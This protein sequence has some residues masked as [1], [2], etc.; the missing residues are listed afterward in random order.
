M[1]STT[2]L[3]FL[4]AVVL[5]FGAGACNCGGVG[6][7]DNDAGM[8]GGRGDGGDDGSGDGGP[9]AQCLATGF[10]CQTASGR[11]CCSGTCSNGSCTEPTFCKGPGTA[12]TAGTECCSN[13]CLEGKCSATQCLDVGQGCSQNGSCCTFNCSGGTCANIPGQ[14]TGPGADGGSQPVCRVL[15]QA[16]SAGGDCCSRNCQGGVCVRSF[17]CNAYNDICL[18]NADCCSNVC[19]STDGGAGY[20]VT[21]TGQTGCDQSGIPCENGTNC[22]TRV[23]LDQGSGVK[24]CQPV[25][26][27]RVAGDYCSGDTSCCGG[28]PTGT[29]Q[30]VATSS[31][32]DNGQACRAPGTIC[33]KPTM[34]LA[35]GGYDWVRLPDGGTF[36]VNNETNCCDGY[37]IPGS[38]GMETTCRLDRSGVPR[39]FGGTGFDGGACPVSG[40]TGEPGCCIAAGDICQFR[41]QC[42]NGALCIPGDGG[43]SRCGQVSCSP[44][45]A[46]CTFGSNQC[47]SGTECLPAGELGFACQVPNPGGGGG[48][49]G[50]GTDG[51][52]VDGGSCRPNG[53]SCS[54]A[55]ACCSGICTNGTCQ[56]PATCQPSGS[57][58]TV[59]GDCCSGLTC[60]ITGGAT[61]GT[62]GQGSTTC[63][64]LGQACSTTV[65]CCSGL[66]CLSS[67][68][69]PCTGTT[70]CS[71]T[72]IIR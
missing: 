60:N 52:T 59:T 35:D 50:T 13:S 1:R 24:V 19:S 28:V 38:G 71:C 58:C 36:E 31:R 40:Y 26:G 18:K 21:T 17:T 63:S 16:C 7:G 51:G 46:S 68:G 25:G 23:C 4:G 15:G 14:P 41:D 64:S 29:V 55:S 43:V 30:C 27:C 32:C 44:V 9:G 34:R 49:G 39:C 67:T 5:G 47:C 2:F 56:A 70:A 10:A 48:D 42:C 12:C 8:D 66:N 20:C 62:C 69:A 61:T 53:T 65:G 22:C 45:G 33:G 11:P 6:P 54:A 3:V 57:A 37:K 72:V